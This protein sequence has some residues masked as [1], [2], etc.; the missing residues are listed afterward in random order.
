MQSSSHRG[1]KKGKQASLFASSAR[2]KSRATSSTSAKAPAVTVRRCASPSTVTQSGSTDVYHS[3]ALGIGFDFPATLRTKEVGSTI[4][5][6]AD[7]GT[8]PVFSLLYAS[9]AADEQ[10]LTLSGSTQGGTTF[11]DY[12]SKAGIADMQY[13]SLSGMKPFETTGGVPCRLTTWNT[14][15]ASGASTPAGSV[16]Y[17]YADTAHVFSAFVFDRTHIVDFL[18]VVLSLRQ[19]QW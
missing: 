10:P 3:C 9:I 16:V 6:Y 4:E 15:D 7:A 14:R 2:A 11:D 17:C 8:D 19:E 13:E 12:V 1:G 5:F 18:R